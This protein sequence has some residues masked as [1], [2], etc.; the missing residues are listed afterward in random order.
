MKHEFKKS[1]WQN[2][3]EGIYLMHV[4]F[5]QPITEE[6]LVQVWQYNEEDEKVAAYLM[7]HVNITYLP[8]DASILLQ[9]TISFDGYLLIK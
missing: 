7:H 3:N 5:A 4:K 8:I 1:D 2:P 6:P 9:T